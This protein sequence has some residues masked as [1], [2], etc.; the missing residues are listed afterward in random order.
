MKQIALLVL[1][2]IPIMLFYLL[3]PVGSA[4]AKS[5]SYII[6]CQPGQVA[7]K[8]AVCKD[9]TAQ[10]KTGANQNPVLRLIKDAIDILSFAVGAASIIIIIIS[11]FRFI[12]ASGDSNALASARRGL[13]AAIIGIVIVALAQS[14]VIFVLDN[15]K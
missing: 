6:V 5:G 8:T 11:A 13:L 9:V 7:Y 15:I 3:L 2:I 12:T 4:L 1:A 10:S 14:I